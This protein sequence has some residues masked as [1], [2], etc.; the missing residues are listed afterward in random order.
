MNGNRC[1]FKTTENNTEA[2]HGGTCTRQTANNVINKVVIDHN[3]LAIYRITFEMIRVTKTGWEY[4]TDTRIQKYFLYAHYYDSQ[5]FMLLLAIVIQ[6][7]Y[8]DYRM[9]SD[10]ITKKI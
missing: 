10:R 9:T 5:Y 8:V 1:T 2:E 7:R 3:T 4:D 6:S